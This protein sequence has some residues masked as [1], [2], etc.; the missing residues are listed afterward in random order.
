MTCQ[1]N[2]VYIDIIL[3]K[4]KQDILSLALDLGAII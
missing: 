2:S 4:E 3:M 1:A